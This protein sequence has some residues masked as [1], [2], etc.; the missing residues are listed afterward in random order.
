MITLRHPRWQSDAPFQD[1]PIVVFT[2]AQWDALNHGKFWPSLFA[3]GVMDEL[4]H[5]Q[6]FVFAMSNRYNWGELEGA[7]EVA[8]IIEQNCAANKMGHLYSE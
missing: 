6:S 8:E 4:W 1:I 3:G 5:N 2:R 7:K